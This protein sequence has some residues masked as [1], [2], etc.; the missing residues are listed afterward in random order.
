MQRRD[1]THKLYVR[2]R[3]M[4]GGSSLAFARAGTRVVMARMQR[5]DGAHKRSVRARMLKQCVVSVHH[6]G[7]ICFCELVGIAFIFELM[8]SRI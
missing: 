8:Y 6:D 2:A 5:R 4:A 3:M 1:G 7:K